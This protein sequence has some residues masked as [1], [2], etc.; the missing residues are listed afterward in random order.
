MLSYVI[1]TQVSITCCYQMDCVNYLLF[2][3]FR[4]L[5]LVPDNQ[6]TQR[7]FTGPV[8]RYSLVP[9]KQPL[10]L[11]VNVPRE[12]SVI[13]DAKAME[14]KTRVN[15]KGYTVWRQSVVFNSLRPRQNRRHFANDILKDIFNANVLISI[16]ILLKYIPN[17]PTD[18]I[19]ASVE[20]IARCWNR[21][22]LRCVSHNN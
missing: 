19:P 22:G 7:C 11:W 18:I 3:V 8:I 9:M 10:I 20:I 5:G 14:V 16:T 2:A 12:Y 21:K 15:L 4:F 13:G 17:D 6:I 1:Q